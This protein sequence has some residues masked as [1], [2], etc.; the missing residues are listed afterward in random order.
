MFIERGSVSG[1]R[2]RLLREEI[3]IDDDNDEN[4]SEEE[5]AAILIQSR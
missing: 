1:L 2:S 3:F 5:K 4:L